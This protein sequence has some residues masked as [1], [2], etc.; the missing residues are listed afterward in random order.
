MNQD[1]LPAWAAL[2]A[3]GLVG[4]LAGSFLNVV[5]YRGPRLWGLVDGEERG[6]LAFPRSYCPSCKTQLPL[7]SLAPIF[8]YLAQRG[9]CRAC[10]ASIAVRYPVVEALGALIAVLS[11]SVFGFTP[12]ALAAA[13]FG[14]ALV[15]LAAIDFETGYLPDAL[16]IPL[17]IAGLCVNAAN[18]FVPFSQA[19]FGALAGFVSFWVI[20]DGYE[21]LRGREGL[22]QGDKKLLAAIGAWTGWAMLPAV[23]FIGAVATLAAILF[24]RRGGKDTLEQP[25]PF[26]PGLCL[27]GFVALLAAERFFSAL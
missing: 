2:S 19:S 12:E 23:I 3:A 9:R 25:A 10:G 15:A 7:S 22:G 11:I 6:N 1:V 13:I 14:W 20:G 24:A 17:G 16:T 21:A 5:I 26:G 27:A 4:L 8:S 18:L